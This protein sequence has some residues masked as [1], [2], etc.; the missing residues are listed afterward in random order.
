MRSSAGFFLVVAMISVGCT[1]SPRREDRPEHRS[2]AEEPAKKDEAPKKGE[3]IESLAMGHLGPAPFN[4]FATAS[5]GDWAVYIGSG[6]N[7]VKDGP[8]KGHASV[9]VRALGVATVATVT[10]T[11][12]VVYTRVPGLPSSEPAAELFS[13]KDAPALDTLVLKLLHAFKPDLQQ[14]DLLRVQEGT[15]TRYHA[16]DLDF[17]VAQAQDEKKTVEG[18]EFDCKKV[19]LEGTGPEGEINLCLW[20]SPQVKA[21]G[22]VAFTGALSRREEPFD[23]DFSVVIGGYGSK[24]KK[25]W[26]KSPEEITVD[27]LGP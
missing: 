4:P 3:S 25:E 12:V 5:E 26:G 13:R 16:K 27:S 7:R 6:K 10:D 15:G 11:A 22:V 1:S 21:P 9:L 18:K 14:I 19:T 20:M 2:T 17:W 23:I 24:E 8:S